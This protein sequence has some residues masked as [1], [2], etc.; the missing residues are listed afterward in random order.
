MAR[1]L[2]PPN[3]DFPQ[4]GYSPIGNKARSFEVSLASYWKIPPS[5]V[6]AF[7][8]GSQH[9]LIPHYFSP[10]AR[11]FVFHVRGSTPVADPPPPQWNASILVIDLSFITSPPLVTQ[12]ILFTPDHLSPP[13]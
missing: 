11:Y 12:R 9:P 6:F 4:V 5:F 1:F 10:P 7:S 2:P 13:S 3:P 8:D